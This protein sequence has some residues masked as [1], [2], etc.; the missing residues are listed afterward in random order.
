LLD[1]H[2]AKRTVRTA[3]LQQVRGPVSTARIGA[4]K[5]YA[6]HMGPFREAYGA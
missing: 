3:S 6:S 1:F 4:A 5:A 2:G